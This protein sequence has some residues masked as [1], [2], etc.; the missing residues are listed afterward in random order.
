MSNFGNKFSEIVNKLNVHFKLD[1][2]DSWV[3]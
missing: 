2:F 1:Y 3:I